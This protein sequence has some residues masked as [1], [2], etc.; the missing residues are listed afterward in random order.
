MKPKIFIDTNVLLDIV[1]ARGSSK[2]SQDVFTAV[3]EGLVEGVITTQSIV[4]AAY[5]V[6][7][8]GP[9]FLNAFYDKAPLLYHYFNEE[10]LD[11]FDFRYA[12]EHKSG[13]FED[14]VQF[15]CAVHSFCDAIITND[16]DFRK[17]HKDENKHITFFTP[18]EF[19]AK[20]TVPSP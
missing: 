8:E 6:R 18:E 2:A 7:K 1:L 19:I 15:A 5:V 11:S 17:N 20:L 12:A 4:D 10:R 3:K 16:K 13:D 14:D 9:E